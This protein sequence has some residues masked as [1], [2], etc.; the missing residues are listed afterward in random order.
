MDQVVLRHIADDRGKALE[1]FI[2]RLAAKQ[3]ATRGG[4][5]EAVESVQ[6]RGLAGAAGPEQPDEFTRLKDE[7][8]ILQKLHAFGGRL[9]KL[10]SGQAGIPADA[11]RGDAIP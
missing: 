1:I 3:N 6:Q 8:Y 10:D 9:A 4:W 11:P 5:A 2:E 7:R